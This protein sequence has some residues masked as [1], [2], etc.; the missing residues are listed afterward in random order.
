MITFSQRKIHSDEKRHKCH[1]CGAVRYESYMRRLDR[2]EVR[3]VSYSYGN[4]RKCWCCK[5]RCSNINKL[6]NRPPEI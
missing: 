5:K 6:V 4:D 1:Y 2:L 3:D